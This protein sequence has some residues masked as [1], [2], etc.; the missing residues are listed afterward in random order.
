MET[1]AQWFKQSNCKALRN[2]CKNGPI[3][4]FFSIFFDLFL[5]DLF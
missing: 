4:Y 5:C 2:T 1:V 3:F